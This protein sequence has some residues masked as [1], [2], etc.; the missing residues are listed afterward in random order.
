MQ[1]FIVSFR[2]M[3]VIH[4]ARCGRLDWKTPE[5]LAP[6]SLRDVAEII[7]EFNEEAAE[8]I[9]VICADLETGTARDVTE[10]ALLFYATAEFNRTDVWP[11]WLQHIAPE[12]VMAAE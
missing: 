1:H 12:Y 10:D 8:H 9:R 11:W 3:P 4:A 7:G 6:H 2:W 5:W